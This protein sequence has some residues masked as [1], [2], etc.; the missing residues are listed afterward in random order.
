MFNQDKII[1]VAKECGAD[2]IHPG[3]GFLA[4]N[5]EFTK[6][7]NEN[8]IKFIGPGAETQQM[9]GNKTTARRIAQELNLPTVPGSSGSIG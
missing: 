8:G 9:A 4:E 1:S 6:A 2:A 3:Y 7:C 5:A